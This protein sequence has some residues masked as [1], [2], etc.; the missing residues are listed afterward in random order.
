MKVS[1][2]ASIVTYTPLKPHHIIT[3]AALAALW[4]VSLAAA[5]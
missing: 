4:P 3:A 5:C 2:L 1:I